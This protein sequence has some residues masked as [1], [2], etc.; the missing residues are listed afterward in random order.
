MRSKLLPQQIIF[1]SLAAF[2]LLGGLVWFAP[3][4]QA[5]AIPTATGVATDTCPPNMDKPCFIT[6][7]PCV[8][9]AI[10]PPVPCGTEPAVTQTPPR[11][12][13]TDSYPPPPG[14]LTLTPCAANSADCAKPSPT[15]DPC[16]L[17]MSPILPPYCQTPPPPPT[18]DTS[19]ALA[20]GRTLPGCPPPCWG[21]MP[22][23]G[24]IM[25]L[26]PII[27]PNKNTPTPGD[28]HPT[29]DCPTPP[30]PPT[31]D[32]PVALTD[33]RT[34]PGCPPPCW[35]VMPLDGQI[36]PIIDPNKNTPTPG[37]PRP[38]PDC[39]TPPPPPTCGTP[40][41][42]TDG[43]TLPGCPPPCWW[44]MPLDG[45]IMPI[46]DPNKNTP[47]PGD[48]HPT[49]DCPTPPPPPTCDTPVALA[50]GRTLPGCPPPCWGVIPLDGQI[51]P[52]TPII[53]PNKNTPTPGDPHPTPDCPTPPPPPTCG[54]PVALADG[55]TLPG[56]PPPCWV[57]I[58]YNDLVMPVTP[59]PT[60]D[61]PTPL[62]PPTCGTPVALTDGRTLPG[63]PPP[64]WVAI[65]YNDLVMPITP[66]PTPDCPTPPP[67][68]TCGTPVALTDGRTLP[69]CPPP[70][71]VAI[72]Y[73][74]LV[75]PITPR[76][77]PDCPTPPP[78]PTCGTPVALA[79]DAPYRAARHLVGV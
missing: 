51:M 16:D 50:D 78:P 45:Q 13:T 25:P 21:V 47:T 75:M 3:K 44:P 29:P 24:Q 7:T 68:P 20:D 72:A 60:P 32:T 39:P 28:P 63:C 61:C 1:L 18:C 65:A 38:T 56:C 76:P 42:L 69:G 5:Q 37:D 57:A 30:P 77:T 55:R 59:H 46:I 26:T 36:M 62:P 33:G 58:A 64:C 41:A 8:A 10:Y 73:N 31:C 43:R 54:T 19:V 74:D 23:D 15:L 4:I 17:V 70:C 6:P 35:G 71:W 67:P 79:D 40:V 14:C 49:P 52:I 53:D 22:L 9:I 27:D 2:M 11:C 34:L 66:R 12:L 48:P